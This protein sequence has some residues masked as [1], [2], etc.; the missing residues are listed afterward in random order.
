MWEGSNRPTAG[1]FRV[2]FSP[3]GGPACQS[4]A[5]TVSM[6]AGSV[7][8]FP[9]PQLPFFSLPRQTCPMDIFKVGKQIACSRL[10][11][12]TPQPHAGFWW[13]IALLLHQCW[14]MC[15]LLSLRGTCVCAASGR[16]LPGLSLTLS[17][18]TASTD[19]PHYTADEVGSSLEMSGAYW[20]P[21][22]VPAAWASRKPQ[23][24]SHNDP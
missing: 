18:L 20:K 8:R 23:V 9:Q 17:S 10:S 14:A 1:I 19:F 7:V 24:Q 13:M 5:L 15:L 16:P 4:C 11:V 21:E 22:G 2:E 12:K 3:F 6:R